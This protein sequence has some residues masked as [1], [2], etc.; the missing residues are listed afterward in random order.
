[1]IPALRDL[2]RLRIALARH[3]IYQ[4]MLAVDP[5]GPPAG[6]IA[7]ERFRLAGAAE[8]IA[9]A[10]LD[11]RIDAFEALPVVALPA[12]IVIPRPRR[13]DQLHGSINAR[14]TRLPASSSAML[15]SSRFA[16]AGDCSR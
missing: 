5:A 16:L 6:Q 11:Q 7:A 1:M 12:E 10:F 9:H 4:P 8:R 2:K 15:S 14:S 13:E 3:P